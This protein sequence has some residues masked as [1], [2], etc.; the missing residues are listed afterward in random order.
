MPAMRFGGT[1]ELPVPISP[2]VLRNQVEYQGIQ[3]AWSRGW[4]FGDPP[5]REV[6]V[7]A[8]RAEVEPR[9]AKGRVAAFFSGGVDSWFTVLDNP[10]ITDL[11]FVR[12]IDLLVD[13]PHQAELAD[14]S[15]TRLRNVAEELGLGFHAVE[16][17][18]RQLTDPLIPW[19][20]FSASAMSAVA[21]FLGPR[22]DRVL[23]A[24]AFD[25]EVQPPIGGN[26]LVENLWSSESLEV[27]EAGGRHSRM[28]RIDA[29]RERAAGTEDTPGLLGE[30][31]AAPTTAAAASSASGRCSHSRRSAASTRSRPFPPTSTSKPS[32]RSRSPGRLAP[33]LGR[34]ARRYP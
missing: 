18:L 10:D 3:R 23:V 4:E 19:E 9:A 16:T 30:P 21:L 13:A 29:G 28:E 1:L 34:R 27:F 2:R 6:E 25:H 24:G 26:R 15:R 8:P 32:P 31:R 7:D 33:A 20:A 12:G 17:N 5:L 22:F 11:V 14:R